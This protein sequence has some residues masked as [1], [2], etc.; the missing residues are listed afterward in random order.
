MAKTVLVTGASGFIAAHIVNPFLERGYNV[1]G[2]V[3]S[4]STAAKV[5]KTHSKYQDQLSF[6]IVP[7]IAAA[8]AFDEA[9]K[10]V[11][12]IIHTA[13]P[14]V[15]G[16]TDFENDLFRPAINGTTSILRAAQKNNS[17]IKRIVITSSFAANLDP[18]KGVR[19][20]FTYTDSDWNPV[21]REAAASSSDGVFAYVASKTFAERA[22]WD[23]V[24]NEKPEFTIATLS[25]PMVYG[26]V[27]HHVE[28]MSS[29]NT[30]AGDFYRL[31]NGSEKEV[32]ESA[33]WAFVDVRDVATAHVLAFEKPEAANQRYLISSSAYNY[34]MV[35]DIIR[36][37]FPELRELT[38]KGKT[39]EPLPDVYKLD[40]SKATNQLGIVFTPLEKTVEDTVNNLLELQ[41][42]LNGS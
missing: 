39:G 25:P 32:P 38:P 18:T 22:A 9:V 42:K 28:D 23:Y 2:T 26:P 41:K 20:G 7:D 33:F 16:A 6:A 36:E 29:L 4:E 12:G 8:N 31:I 30:S 21:T 24:E 11:D 14:F 5:K 34:Q 3:R 13:S 37:K 1:R 19:P 40:T 17:N 27:I 10:G 15:L 35:C